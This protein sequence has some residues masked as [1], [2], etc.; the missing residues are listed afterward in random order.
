MRPD[1]NDALYALKQIAAPSNDAK[2]N[3]EAQILIHEAICALE[4]RPPEE[5]IDMDDPDIQ[6]CMTDDS[7]PDDHGIGV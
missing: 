4:G 3:H 2:A 1:I 5:A 6:K 7:C